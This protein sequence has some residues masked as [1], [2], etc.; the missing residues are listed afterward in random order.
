[1]AAAATAMLQ[2]GGQGSVRTI[3]LFG[4]TY[5]F[6]TE[7]T[8]TANYKK[9][10]DELKANE[11]TDS[12]FNDAFQVDLLKEIYNGCF[13]DGPII[14]RAGC[15][16][17]GL[18]L[19]KLGELYAEKMK[20]MMAHTTSS[21]KNGKT[22]RN[23][24]A[25]G[26]LVFTF[27][28]LKFGKQ[29]SK[30]TLNKINAAVQK[31]SSAQSIFSKVKHAFQTVSS[32]QVSTHGMVWNDNACF[33]IST[34]Q[35]LFSIPQIRTAIKKH[36]CDSNVFAQILDPDHEITEVN[37]AGVMC[38]LFNLFEKLGENM[39]LFSTLTN[40]FKAG[41]AVPYELLQYIMKNFFANSGEPD[42]FGQQQDATDF[43]LFMFDVFDKLKMPITKLFQFTITTTLDGDPKNSDEMMWTLP[44]EKDGSGNVIKKS[45][46]QPK[47]LFSTTLS[48]QVEHDKTLKTKTDAITLKENP[49][50]L[51]RTSINTLDTGEIKLNISGNPI[52]NPSSGEV[53]HNIG[54][55]YN[56]IDLTDIP[57]EFTI[58]DKTFKQFGSIQYR[59]HSNQASTGTDASND[60]GTAGHYIYTRYD[61]S[62]K[63]GIVYNDRNPG[64]Y[65]D[66]ST[67]SNPFPDYVLIYAEIGQKEKEAHFEEEAGKKV[68]EIRKEKSA[69]IEK[70]HADIKA[71]DD[72]DLDIDFGEFL[73]SVRETEKAG[74]SVSVSSGG[75]DPTLLFDSKRSTGFSKTL[76]SYA[77]R[78][79]NPTISTPN[80]PDANVIKVMSYEMDEA[81][82]IYLA[83]TDDNEKKQALVTYAT[84]SILKELMKDIKPIPKNV[85]QKK[86]ET[87]AAEKKASASKEKAAVAAAFEKDHRL[88]EIANA[89]VVPIPTEIAAAAAVAASEEDEEV[90]A[91]SAEGRR[92]AESYDD[93][94]E[95]IP[96][97]S[98]SRSKA[99]SSDELLTKIKERLEMAKI[100]KDEPVDGTAVNMIKKAIGMDKLVDNKMEI[101][102]KILNNVESWRNNIPIDNPNREKA[103]SDY[104]T[105]LVIKSKIHAQINPKNSKY[106]N[107]EVSHISAEKIADDLIAN[108]HMIKGERPRIEDMAE[109]I[110]EPKYFK[111]LSDVPLLQKEYAAAAKEIQKRSNAAKQANAKVAAKAAAP[112]T[113]EE[114]MQ[115]G[116]L[117][118]ARAPTA[119]LTATS[120][121][122]NAASAVFAAANMEKKTS[123]SS[124]SATTAGVPAATAA[125]SASTNFFSRVASQSKSDQMIEIL[126]KGKFTIDELEET[127]ST[128][129]LRSNSDPTI[130]CEPLWKDVLTKAQKVPSNPNSQFIIG[131]CYYLPRGGVEINDDRAIENFTMAEE[132]G[133]AP[134]QCYLGII[135]YL[136]KNANAFKMFDAAKDKYPLAYKWLGRCY[137]NGLGVEM[138]RA[139]AKEN[140]DLATKKGVLSAQ[141]DFMIEDLISGNYIMKKIIEERGGIEKCRPLWEAARKHAERHNEPKWKAVLGICYLLGYG[142]KQDKEQAIK[143]L[144]EAGDNATAQYYLGDYYRAIMRNNVEAFKS[145][146]KAADKEYTIAEFQTG[147]MY[148]MGDGIARNIDLA[149]EYYSKAAKKGNKEAITMLRGIQENETAASDAEMRTEAAAAAQ[150]E[151]NAAKAAAADAKNKAAVAEVEKQAAAAAAKRN[152]NAE[153][154]RKAEAA[155]AAQEAARSLQQEAERAAKAAEENARRLQQEAE[156]AAAAIEEA[157][158]K[159]QEANAE[160]NRQAKQERIKS[161]NQM[162]KN[163]IDGKYENKEALDKVCGKNCELW[164]TEAYQYAKNHDKEPEQKFVLGLCYFWGRGGVEKNDVT[165][166]NLFKKIK[167]PIAKYYLG[168]CYFL[169]NGVEKDVR[170]AANL[171]EDA[172]NSGLM[173][174]QYYLGICY[175]LGQGREKN[176]KK[177]KELFQQAANQNHKDAIQK[178]KILQ[179][180]GRRTLR[181]AKK[182]TLR[183]A[184]RTLRTNK[185]TLRASKK[186]RRSTLTK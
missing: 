117:K 11:K 47:Q 52:T 106:A 160:A 17:F 20:D 118:A 126:L 100:V 72:S 152:A 5:Q 140:Y 55:R 14:S 175:Q 159:Q 46:D 164:W 21:K 73:D 16:H 61:L 149:K 2:K 145:Y 43:L 142:V 4:E 27:T 173:N 28:F 144:E 56:N 151:A 51:I 37:Y 49:Y 41:D 166:F 69:F 12:R 97:N 104:I 183:A 23:E 134:A 179:K 121:K 180:G 122:V 186:L 91:S 168:L 9:L 137:L 158:Q 108:Y 150:R 13:T 169:G 35:F 157:R 18:L 129:I 135:A 15:E 123:A 77:K 156:R 62:S 130:A 110:M 182:R 161:M 71:E 114:E 84:F 143:Y 112:K 85:L 119:A 178:L 174:A 31:L 38:A 172:A 40:D 90:S 138:N 87:V 81:K 83:S 10:L 48:S 30:E 170:Q 36:G 181:A 54:E 82:R 29:P 60:T 96:V 185:R 32:D 86:A 75:G 33:C 63:K 109:H 115:L 95:D 80:T 3:E 131:L 113:E 148:E 120:K 167:L 177:A 132:A 76:S 171:F 68:A 25:N 7:P 105:M 64:F 57:L 26:D 103:H 67:V 50:L 89:K 184:T 147:F 45:K 146:M 66:I 22:S 42:A 128:K 6:P 141:W 19:E 124:V 111:A 65:P 44:L 93:E 34:I 24:L 101:M 153:T 58:G 116:A 79:R 162:I 176:I 99:P 88:P 39:A 78:T 8:S 94:K 136:E 163:L 154:N 102:D 125:S 98:S 133:F 1:M 155:A 92:A 127:T 107:K 53:K 59:G 74:E 165:A 139:L 70:M